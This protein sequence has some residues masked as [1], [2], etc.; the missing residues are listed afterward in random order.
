[1][2][3]LPAGPTI[4]EG[5]DAPQT[6][7]PRIDHSPFLNDSSRNEFQTTVV[8]K[9]IGDVQGFV[10]MYD[11]EEYILVADS[12]PSAATALANFIKGNYF[13]HRSNFENGITDI[14]SDGAY[15]EGPPPRSVMHLLGSGLCIDMYVTCYS[16]EW[17]ILYLCYHA[18][19][20]MKLGLSVMDQD[21]RQ[22]PNS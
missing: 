14:S 18:A 7:F 9:F 5:T 4:T 11:P 2:P 3:P 10:R 6:L 1:M 13:P 15:W 21:V 19:D 16:H 22:Q 8:R 17:V 12:A 20:P